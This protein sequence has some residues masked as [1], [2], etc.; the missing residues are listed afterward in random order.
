[1][2][3]LL[4]TLT[5]PLLR[6][7][8]TG[9]F[10]LS[11]A[12]S[13]RKCPHFSGAPGAQLWDLV[14]FGE[15]RSS[16]PAPARG[17]AREA[18]LDWRQK[19]PGADLRAAPQRLVNAGRTRHRR[20]TR[21]AAGSLLLREVSAARL[22]DASLP[23]PRASLR[24]K[25]GAEQ[26]E[27]PASPGPAFRCPGRELRGR[28]RRPAR[29]GRRAGGQAGKDSSASPLQLVSFRSPSQGGDWRCDGPDRAPAG[30]RRHLLPRRLPGLHGEWAARPFPSL[31]ARPSGP[32]RRRELS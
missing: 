32:K 19:V 16:S 25:P 1:M 20:N 4:F 3:F 7:G 6:K 14:T 23:W 18:G 22:L 21:L 10:I 15:T 2:R 5:S 26:E 27:A 30:R 12:C 28:G 24:A 9:L 11:A 31:S 8:P 29:G 17:S 13:P